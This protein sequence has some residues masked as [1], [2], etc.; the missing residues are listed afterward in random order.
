[1]HDAPRPPPRLFSEPCWPHVFPPDLAEVL[2]VLSVGPTSLSSSV[3]PVRVDGRPPIHLHLP[4]GLACPALVFMAS[5]AWTRFPTDV[6]NR[7]VSTALRCPSMSTAELPDPWSLRR[8]NTLAP[9]ES[10][11]HGRF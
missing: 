6:P 1:M 5:C 4:E 7:A 8:P 10:D 11:R 3:S 2:R 9:A